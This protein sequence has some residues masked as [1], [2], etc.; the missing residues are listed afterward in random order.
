MSRELL[1]RL[2]QRMQRELK[3]GKEAVPGTSL[4]KSLDSIDDKTVGFPRLIRK[5]VKEQ[6]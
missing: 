3:G 5:G 6:T 2:V 4:Y 1:T